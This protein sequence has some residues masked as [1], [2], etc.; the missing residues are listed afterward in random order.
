MIP[1]GLK[2]CRHLLGD[3][4]TR[5]GKA[6]VTRAVTS[7]APRFSISTD[8]LE[9]GVQTEELT[10]GAIAFFCYEPLICIQCSLQYTGIFFFCGLSGAVGAVSSPLCQME[11]Y[12]YPLLRFQTA[13]QS[14]DTK[15]INILRKTRL[16]EQRVQTFLCND[17]ILNQKCPDTFL[18]MASAAN[19][20]PGISRF[21]AGCCK[22]GSGFWMLCRLKNSDTKILDMAWFSFDII[23]QYGPADGSNTDI[24][25]QRVLH[26]Y[27]PSRTKTP[28]PQ[29][30]VGAELRGILPDC[31]NLMSLVVVQDKI[32][33]P[34]LRRMSMLWVHDLYYAAGECKRSLA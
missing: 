33:I 8:H 7:F 3:H 29:N 21:T 2:E 9:L 5:Y 24:Q 27:S 31:S 17:T 1:L 11:Q 30:V 15:Y 4:F 18:T 25:T 6:I 22:A 19:A 23:T 16:K 28:R 13:V 12:P 14:L 34:F 26:V 20:T 32:I 10:Y